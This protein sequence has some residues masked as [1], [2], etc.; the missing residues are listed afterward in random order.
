[1][2]EPARWR[3]LVSV[4]VPVLNEERHIAEALQSVFDQD[5]PAG[6]IEILVADGGSTD[7]TRAVVSEFAQADSRVRLLDNPDRNQAAGLNVAIEASSGEVVARLDGHAAWRP[8][9]LSR[10]VDLLEAT[11]ADNVGGSMEA[12]G[13]T[14][15]SRAA[16]A[17]T[18]SVLG[19]GGATYRRASEQREADTVFLG[20]FRRSAL[21]RAG[22]F[23]EAYP[24]HEDYDMNHRI[25]RT[26]GLVVFSPEI[27]TRYYARASWRNLALQYFH[28][29]Q[30]KARVARESPA[31]IRPY[32]LA[33][34]ALAAVLAAA[35]AAVVTGRSRRTGLALLGAYVAACLVAGSRVGR[36]ETP[37]VR[38]RVPLVFPVLHL[39]WGFG[40]LSGLLEAVATP[41][42]Q[43][44]AHPSDE[45]AGAAL[46]RGPQLLQQRWPESRRG[47]AHPGT[48]AWRGRRACCALSG[49][50]TV[51]IHVRQRG[52]IRRRRPRQGQPLLR[53]R[54]PRLRG[55][56]Q[57][58]SRP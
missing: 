50:K 14:A 8:W 40:F 37:A 47:A 34:P 22:R 4:V 24:P 6:L 44:Q 13:E 10:C 36:E 20:C 35:L 45:T 16:A 7:R 17:A 29:G 25:R 27:P 19:V 26:G 55:C 31:V 58:R 9:H 15:V 28:Y 23:N 49:R 5:Y 39:S 21:R 3:P 41:L 52:R 33:P 43:C 57:P 54:M 38:A 56:L 46:S 42:G 12:V 48:P 51:A 2:V 11:G 1:M 18:R 53:P 30:G 32:H